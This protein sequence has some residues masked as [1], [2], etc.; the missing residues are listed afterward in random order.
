MRAATKR[1]ADKALR[2][3]R[4]LN[5]VPGAQSFE[6]AGMSLWEYDNT[7]EMGDGEQVVCEIMRRAEA[8]PEI[9]R[10]LR[11]YPARRYVDYEGWAET[12]RRAEARLS[13]RMLL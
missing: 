5:A 7:G 9:D 10:L 11:T 6:D 3:L 8:D 1:R 13:E 12:Y 2:M 4:R